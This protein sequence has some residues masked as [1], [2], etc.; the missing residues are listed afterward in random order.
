MPIHQTAAAERTRVERETVL[1]AEV[2][3]VWEA[4]TDDERLDEW[5]GEDTDRDV[6]EVVEQERVAFTWE[7]PGSGPS[8]VEFGVE[9]VPGGTRLVVTETRIAGP[10]ALASGEWDRRLGAL[11][12]AT[13]LVAA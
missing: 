3:E 7:R 10:V 5:L 11:R 1:P 6:E 12:R 9:A 13:L 8:R 4:L 2:E